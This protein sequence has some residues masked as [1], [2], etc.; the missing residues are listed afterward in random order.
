MSLWDVT[1]K[2]EM[3]L[4]VQ[5][6]SS[7]VTQSMPAQ[8]SGLIPQ[9]NSNP[10]RKGLDMQGTSS[11][12]SLLINELPQ[13]EGAPWQPSAS[14]IPGSLTRNLIGSLVASASKL[15]DT[16]DQ[17]GIWFILQDLSVRTEGSESSN[18]SKVDNFC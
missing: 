8:P 18:R 6:S 10:D 17:L 7:N 1:A 11:S 16:D 2:N 5:P 4:V 14:H 3:N 12:D 13:T 15:N 9:I